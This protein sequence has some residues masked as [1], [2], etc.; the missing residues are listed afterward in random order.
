MNK[1]NQSMYD[2]CKE[3]LHAYVLV[4]T[5]DGM[6]F[7]GIMTGLDDEHAYFAIPIEAYERDQTRN[8]YPPYVSPYGGF[9]DQFYGYPGYGYPGGRFR[10]L[11]IPL[12]ALTAL[13]LLPWY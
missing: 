5:T 3:H 13:A 12:A 8:F 9:G 10:R 1:N 2:L 4:E 7:D 6:T 11:V